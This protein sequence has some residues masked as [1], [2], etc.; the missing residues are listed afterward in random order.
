[1][2]VNEIKERFRVFGDFEADEVNEWGFLINDVADE[3][4]SRLLPE[5]DPENSAVITAAAALALY[6]YT[7]IQ[8]VNG[9]S[10]KAGDLTV[11]PKVSMSSAR[12]LLSEMEKAASGLIE[13][14]DEAKND[15]QF[16]AV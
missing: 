1:M 14:F 5:T 3:I 10:I 7:V 9:A 6:R 4:E 16:K 11:T 13:P 8:G 15:F 2:N 12:L